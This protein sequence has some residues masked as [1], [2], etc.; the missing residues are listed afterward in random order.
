MGKCEGTI[1]AI[2]KVLE[3]EGRYKVGINSG[4]SLGNTAEE[5]W[6]LNQIGEAMGRAATPGPS[7]GGSSSPNDGWET[8][9]PSSNGFDAEPITGTY[10]MTGGTG[11]GLR[12][13]LTFA[14]L[15]NS[16]NDKAGNTQIILN[17]IL[18]YGTGY[19]VGDVISCDIWDDD[20]VDSANRIFRIKEVTEEPTALL[21]VNNGT[22]DIT[23]FAGTEV[24][25]SWEGDAKIDNH[26]PAG[27]LR[28]WDG[29]YKVN[30][31]SGAPLNAGSGIW[32]TNYCLEPMGRAATPDSTYNGSDSDFT[33]WQL[34][35]GGTQFDGFGANPISGT[36]D[37]LGGSG[38]NIRMNISFYPLK[39]DDSP[40]KARNTKIVINRVTKSG[41]GYSVGD[42]LSPAI[43][44]NDFY[45]SA[46]RIIKITEVTEEPQYSY[47]LKVKGGDSIYTNP[48]SS[49]SYAIT[50]T[51]TTTYN[52]KVTGPG[53]TVNS[54]IKVTIAA[55]GNPTASIS[56]DVSSVIPPGCAL[57]TWSSTD[58][59]TYS[60]EA[61]GVVINSDPGASNTGGYQVCPT[62]ET[63]Y[64]YIV[65]AA[66]GTT[67]E[68]SV[69]I[70][71]GTPPPAQ[72]T[73]SISASPTSFVLGDPNGST[74]TWS[75]SNGSTYTLT[76]G[77][78]N[79]IVASPGANSPA[80]G[81]KVT[82]SQ[83]TRYTYTVT[84]SEG[85]SASANVTVTVTV[86]DRPTVSLSANPT[87]VIVGGAQSDRCSTL[88]WSSSGGDTFTLT[89]V[90]N[91]GASGT[92]TVCPTSTKT[93]TFEATNAGGSNQDSVEI[94]V[95]TRPSVTISA[96][97]GTS[98]IAGN[99]VTIEWSTS[100]DADNFVWTQGGISNT[101]LTS[102]SEE[103]PIVTTTYSG[104]ATGLGG[105]SDTASVT[106][107]V[108]QI[109]TLTVDY[110]TS[111]A[112]NTQA[113]IEYTSNYVNSS[114]TLTPTYYYLDDVEVTGDTVNLSKGD[115]AESGVGTTEV[116][117]TYTTT[118]PYTDRGPIS[119]AFVISG[120][121]DGGPVA[122]SATVPI[123]IDITPENLNIIDSEDLLADQEPVVT[124]DTDVL[125][126]QYLIDDIDID[127]EVKADYP[128]Q[129]QL[130]NSGTWE[131]V[132]EL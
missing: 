74:L 34:R 90:N 35:Q 85:L 63:T 41:T 103:R 37:M 7:L 46:D 40:P 102:E 83:T 18:N 36:Y 94:V 89:D 48:G 23:V 129:V 53:G 132:R 10:D 70:S 113:D 86:P 81:F 107:R 24:T 45:E 76:D 3:W 98:I 55:P 31:N 119:V 118:I 26:P 64:T 125:T 14:P 47:E 20:F 84:T 130:N 22:N 27:K 9:D 11:T 87:T 112:Y 92:A 77:A 6:D 15:R 73:A 58:G 105:T 1:M 106:V 61:N 66:D 51:Q 4:D 97:P 49:G 62:V 117:D 124:P 79:V 16:S 44:N 12:M 111:I 108:S 115:S 54:D 72:P 33:G 104:Y 122:S 25:L 126:E 69:T 100:G 120:S 109:P 93:Y 28:G 96:N 99:S 52:Y 5:L 13:N 39:N 114:L 128:I 116:T 65:T 42:I 67:A 127:V 32:D 43:W 95:Y 29:R 80:N 57:L 82:P 131:N 71:I 75:S 21:R 30:L 56:S 91:P 123:I 17:K 19:S 68:D 2:G 78:N 60:L 88:T 38:S 110:P 8:I 50:P 59:S 101:N 121:G